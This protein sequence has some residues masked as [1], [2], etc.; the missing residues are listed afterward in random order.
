LHS[1]GN[2]GT[3]LGVAVGGDGADLSDLVVGR[4]FL[5]V[6]LELGDDGCA[7]EVEAAPE[8]HRVGAGSN[9][10]GAFSDNSLGENRGGGGAVGS[11]VGGFGSDLAH[12]LGG[13]ALEL[14]LELDFLGDGDAVLGDTG[15]AERLVEHHIAA[16][17]AERHLHGVGE[18]VHAARH[19]VASI[20]AE[21][22][23]LG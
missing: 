23:F 2:F 1:L 20:D 16:L 15:S 4:D 17:G 19:A 9:R 14:V 8:V 10:L 3:N 6:L 11:N 18:N 5:G 13:H 22:D 7:R 21:F 12:A